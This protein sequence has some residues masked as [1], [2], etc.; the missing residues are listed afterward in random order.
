MLP[1]TLKIKIA[2]VFLILTFH[3]AEAQISG[4]INT[5]SK[6]TATDLSCNTVTVLDA[7]GF[8]VG[9]TILIIQMKGATMD[10]T[11]TAA[12]GNLTSLNNAGNYE[13][14]TIK[15]VS[16]NDLTL[17]NTLLRSYTV[18]DLVQIVSVPQY[19]NV[20]ITGTLTAKDWDGATGGVLVFE[21]SGTVIMNAD[22]DVSALG[23]RGGN[24]SDNG[25]NCGTNYSYF[26][27]TPTTSGG[28]TRRRYC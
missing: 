21:A 7:S 17:I 12:F 3:L 14:A 8:T 5:Y 9:D 23:F 28:K 16:G 10:E 4:I 22:I 11:N 2:L 15:T 26:S 6:V 18:A 19:T 24:V 13:F 25:G 20:A 27:S 1:F